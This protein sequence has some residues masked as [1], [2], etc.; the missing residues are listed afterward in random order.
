MDFG[1]V[2]YPSSVF[3]RNI[4]LAITDEDTSRDIDST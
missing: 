4:S 3:I 1:G 2:L